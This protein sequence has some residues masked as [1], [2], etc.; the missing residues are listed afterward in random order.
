MIV[1]AGYDVM[2]L[3]H[4]EMSADDESAEALWVL[5]LDENLRYLRLNK[6]LLKMSGTAD[7]HIGKIAEALTCDFYPKY[8]VLAYSEP[9]VN[10]HHDGWLHGIDERIRESPDLLNF[11]MLGQ[12]A[13]DPTGYYSS[14][15]RYSFRDYIGLERLP[16]AASF[17][18]PHTCP[19]DCPACTQHDR[20]LEANPKRLLA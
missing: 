5:L 3:L 17:A 12:V 11:Y 16:R 19:C 10:Q 8:F 1:E 9:E 2:T 20:M 6:A 14:V 18:G 7:L 15:P 4:G 13:F